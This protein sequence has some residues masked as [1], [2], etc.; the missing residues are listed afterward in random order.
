MFHFIVFFLC[1]NV[2]TV[3]MKESVFHYEYRI[4]WEKIKN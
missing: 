2:L 4:D 1:E 3:L